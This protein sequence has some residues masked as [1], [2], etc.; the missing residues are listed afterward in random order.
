MSGDTGWSSMSAASLS[1]W[2]MSEWTIWPWA[3]FTVAAAAAQTVRNAAQRQLTRTLGTTGATHVRFLFGVPFA[4]VFL[5]AIVLATGTAPPRPP[6]AFWPWVTTGALTQIAATAMMLAAMGERSFLVVIAYTKTEPIQ[7][8]L[9][10]LAVLGDPITLAVGAAITVA[11]TGVVTMSLRPGQEAG[12][13]RPVALGLGAAACFAVSAVAF[14]GAILSLDAGYLTAA[15]TTLCIAL[16]LQALLLSVWLA[17]RDRT[18]LV[19]VL[20]AWRPS[21]LAGF[22]GALASQLWFLGFAL[23]TAANVRTL[24]L[25]EVLFAQG[26]SRLVFGQ[27][28]TARELIGVVLIVVGV[29]MLLWAA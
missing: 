10:G 2:D 15:G 27:R 9:F 14:R 29:V 3:A 28:A 18:V 25:V 26:V 19:A 6:L 22:M 5:A 13:A 1:G 24:A 8:A 11:T 12:G 23:T 17:V 21:L 4:V 16:A 7:V 20:R